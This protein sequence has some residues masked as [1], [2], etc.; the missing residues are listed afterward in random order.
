MMQKRRVLHRIMAGLITGCMLVAVMPHIPGSNAKAAGIT[1]DGNIGD[2]S[3]ISTQASQD[4]NITTWAVAQDANNLYFMVQDVNGNQWGYHPAANGQSITFQYTNGVQGN[5]NSMQ[6]IWNNGN[7]LVKDGWYQDINGAGIS[8]QLSDDQT[9]G[10]WEY[11]VP[12]SF[13]ADTSFTLSYCG[14]TVSSDAI[15]SLDGSQMGG[16]DNSGNTDNSGS[17]GSEETGN[18]ENGSDNSGATENPRYEGIV[19]DGSFSDWDAVQKTKLDDDGNEVAMVWDGDYIYL[20]F[21]TMSNN[22][23]SLAWSGPNANGQ[24]AITTDLG[25]T[26]L[27]Q[28]THDNGVPG[29]SG[30]EGTSTAVNTTEWG[31]PPYMWEIA[32]PTSS[33]PEYKNTISFGYYTLDPVIKDVANLQGGSGSD[34]DNDSDNN[35][36]FNGIVIDG[37]YGDWANYP[38]TLIQYATPGTQD[39]KPDGEAALYLNDGTLYAHVVTEMQS[40]IQEK[41]GEFTSAVTIRLNND[42]DKGFMPQF[43]AVDVAGNINYSPQLSGLAQGTYELYMIDATGWKSATNISELESKGNAIYGHMYMT[44][45]ASADN[46]EFEMDLAKLAEKFGMSADDIRTVEGKWGRIGQ[47]WVSTAGTSTGTWAGLLICFAGVGA[48]TYVSRRRKKMVK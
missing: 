46:M 22:W 12:K 38:H 29:V 17:A 23:N 1:I 6:I 16:E 15:P 41:G 2:W 18:T 21:M 19:I 48:A 36:D 9:Q 44:I 30:L 11:S 5:A 10:T 24:F 8:Y 27:I 47:Q 31:K 40:H 34:E 28:L 37:Q 26:E 39:V 7:P 43:I 32:I 35:K 14:T 20:Y 4:G 13:L 25:R 33:L 42:D 45:G 3:G